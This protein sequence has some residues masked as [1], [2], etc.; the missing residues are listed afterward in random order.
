MIYLDNAATTK[1]F[2]EVIDIMAKSME[3][4]WANP[5]SN[6]S[7]SDRV[8]SKIEDVRHLFAEDL[9]CSDEEIYFTSGGCESNSMAINGFLKANKGY[10]L[11]CSALEHTSVNNLA[12]HRPH[13]VAKVTIPN[14]EL[15]NISA[16]NIAHTIMHFNL[17]SNLKPLVTISAANSEIG[18]IQDIKAISEVVHKYNGILHCDAVQLFPEQRLDVKDLDIDMLSISA[19]KF[20]G[21]RGFG[22]LYIKKG[23]QIAPIIY[24]SQENALRGGTYNTA[25]ILGAGKAL[26]I[27]RADN[28]SNKIKQLRDT[29]Y[30]G[31]IYL[32][33]VSLNGPNIFANRLVNNISLT[34]DGVNAEK[35]MT[36]C[37][38]SDIIISRGSACQAFTP[39]PSHALKA[40][41]LS[42][43][44]ALNTIR[45]SLGAYNTMKDI[46]EAI[47]IIRQLIERIR[48]ENR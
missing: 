2:P 14:D 46:D 42:D 22:V 24:G 28:S 16:D 39:I 27:T 5:S 18:V 41:G 30:Y 11:Y 1:P 17:Y 6:N 15:G 26:E 21:P 12:E 3:T 32:P 33:G 43:E 8:K 7:L 34:I 19:Q 13:H 48:D 45:L 23:M 47:T 31:L 4:D 35:L 44:E 40:I 10:A 25:A 36:L 20:N 9:N 38:L 37:N 29:L